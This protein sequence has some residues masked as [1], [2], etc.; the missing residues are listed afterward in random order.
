MAQRLRPAIATAV[1]VA[2]T[3]CALARPGGG[4]PEPTKS[5]PEPAESSG[6]HKPKAT[7]LDPAPIAEAMKKLA[8]DVDRWGGKVGVMVIDVRTGETIAALGEHAAY[9]PASNAKLVTAAAALRRLGGQWRYLTGLY[10]KQSGDAVDELVLR[11]QGDPS[12]KTAD[13]WSMAHDLL[14]A[15]VHKVGSVSV[16]QGYFDDHY[17]SPAFDSQ[18]NE[19][20]PFRAP[21]SAVA[22]NENTATFVVRATKDGKDAAVT[23]DPPGFVDVT[24][25]VRTAGKG[26]PEGVT[27]GLEPRGTRLAAKLGGHVPEGSRVMRIVKRVEDPRLL[28]GYALRA[29]LKELGME[30]GEV[31]LGGDKQKQLLVAHRSAP[32]G[33]LLLS[34]G[35]DS[36]NF[37]AETIFK[38]LGAEG[39]S[40]PATA[41]AAAELATATLQ[42]MGALEPNVVIKNNSDLF[43]ANRI[44]PSA[45]CTLLR[46][47]HRDGAIASEFVA[48]LAVGGVDGTLKGRFRSWAKERA[49]RAKTGTLESV[50]ALSG[51]VLPPPGRSPVAFS[52]LVNGI[53]GKVS[54]ARASI[55]KLVETIAKELYKG[56]R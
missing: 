40:R 10:G 33:E 8:E 35:K 53:P 54:G 37:Y 36:D 25:S 42:D 27:V 38:T 43:D 23:V 6:G 30:V 5:D 2:A 13:L 48:Q 20:A 14:D 55:D 12:L 41:E 39:K 9:N 22:L 28:G 50:A 56:K 24:G 3:L 21:V 17:A 1:A 19:W 18:P 52:V 32:L 4:Q 51:Y 47:A 34:L 15:G 44:T 29:V 45:T 7:T 49:I 11:G 46:A 26:D 31:R 16:D